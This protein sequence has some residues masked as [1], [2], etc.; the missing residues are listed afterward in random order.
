MPPFVATIVKV[1]AVQLF[2]A[3]GVVPLM[4]WGERRLVA[5]L[6]QRVGPNRVGPLGLFQPLADVVKLV[7]KEEARPA[8]ADRALYMLAPII[9]VTPVFLAMVVIPY[10]YG[11]VGYIARLPTSVLLVLA[12]SGLQI[13]GLFLGGWASRSKYTILGALRTSAQMISYELVLAACAFVPVLLAGSLDLVE[14]VDKQRGGWT[15]WFAFAYPPLVLV[16]FA[17]MVV[18]IFA[19]TNRLPF[20]LPEAESELV[21]GYHTEYSSMRF[22][23]FFM[24]EYAAMWNM[25][26]LTITLYLGGWWGPYLEELALEGRYWAAFALGCLYFVLKTS[27]LMVLFIWVRATLPRVRY[28]QLMDFSWKSML[29]AAFVAIA[30]IAAVMT[31]AK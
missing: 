13:Y 4:I 28:D 15:S 19:E 25:S 7:V 21:A 3:A 2:V 16:P 22:A 24:A 6:Q 1:L 8:E 10:S 5:R 31:F 30:A 27:A 20:D 9:A 12:L 23:S 11:D 29:P 14:I 18:S 17:L 26:A